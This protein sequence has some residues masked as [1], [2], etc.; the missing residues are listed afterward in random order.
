MGES[1]LGRVCCVGEFGEAQGLFGGV[2][3][4]GEDVVVDGE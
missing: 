4:N 1:A 3:E 2:R